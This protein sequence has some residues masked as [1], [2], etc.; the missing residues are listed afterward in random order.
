VFALQDIVKTVK[1]RKR[2]FDQIEPTFKENQELAAEVDQ[3]R[4]KVETA[5]KEKTE[6]E[7]FQYNAITQLSQKERERMGKLSSRASLS[8]EKCC[9][10]KFLY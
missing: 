5:E 4:K 8:T 1:Y 6:L 10:Y 3:L 9:E 7:A 2:C